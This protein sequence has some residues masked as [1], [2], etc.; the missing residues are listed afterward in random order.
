M[1]DPFTQDTDRDGVS[2]GMELLSRTDPYAVDSDR[3][4]VIDG[5]E[6]R[7]GFNP[8]SPDTDRDGIPDGLDAN[9]LT[10]MS[11]DRSRL[12]KVADLALNMGTFVGAQY[13]F[14]VDAGVGS[15]FIHSLDDKRPGLDG[16]GLLYYK[17]GDQIQS[18]LDQ[19]DLNNFAQVQQHLQQQQ[20][21]TKAIQQSER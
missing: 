18:A 19:R 13:A 15:V 20:A 9:P 4:G 1:T 5:D 3:D 7:L 16:Q 2:D 8:T 17:D 21:S 12:K 10:P 14:T 11:D 6:L